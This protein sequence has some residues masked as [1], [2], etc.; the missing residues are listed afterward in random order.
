MIKKPNLSEMTEKVFITDDNKATFVCPN[1]K[2]TKTV[3]I[4]PYK[5]LNKMIRIKLKCSCGNS[6]T[7][8]LERRKHYRKKTNVPGEYTQVNSGE[9][10]NSGMMTVKDL[11]RTGLKIQLDEKSNFKIGDRLMVSFHLDDKN[12]SPI[13]KEA[14]ITNMKDSFVGVQFC[15]LDEYDKILGFY[16]LR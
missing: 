13:R 15:R 2:K 10:K 14:V 3:D 6:H 16:L 5:N 8:L 9:K 12:Q 11:S 7:V 4:S 1:C